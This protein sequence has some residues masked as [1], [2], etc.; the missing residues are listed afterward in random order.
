[1]II[2][3]GWLKHGDKDIK[4]MCK[5][6]GGIERVPSFLQTYHLHPHGNEGELV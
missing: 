2:G 5:R 1:M 4:G 3:F 6:E